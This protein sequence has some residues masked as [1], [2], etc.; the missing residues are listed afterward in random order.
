MTLPLLAEAPLVPSAG[1]GP[2]GRSDYES[3]PEEP[4]CELIHG[5]F[6]VSPSP[7]GRH[8]TV[9]LALFR[10]LHGIARKAGGRAL[11]APLDVHLNEHTVVQPDLVYISSA[12]KGIVQA[13]IEGAPNLVIE[14]V[15]PGTARLDRGEK[16]RA[17]ARASVAE[18]WI[19][20]PQE[21]QIQ[22]LRGA[23]G[24]FV[25]ELSDGTLYRSGVNPEIE[26]DLEELWRDV[27]LDLGEE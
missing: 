2:F 17:Y 24:M 11:A 23:E 25:V 15:S 6:F 9:V 19:V 3:L 12:R 16:L 1:V 21:R 20:D 7:S 8:Q 5:R 14:V 22:F 26:L 13:A 10:W 27:A 4:R 18:Y